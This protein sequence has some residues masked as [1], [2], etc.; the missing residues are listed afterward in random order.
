MDD[1]IVQA[2]YSFTEFC[3]LVLSIT[4]RNKEISINLDVLFYPFS[5]VSSQFMYFVD[6]LLGVYTLILLYSLYHYIISLLI[7]VRVTCSEI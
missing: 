7:S 4:E 1:S 6:I 5:S 3:L 2:F